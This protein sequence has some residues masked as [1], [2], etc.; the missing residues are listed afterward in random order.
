MPASAAVC[1]FDMKTWDGRVIKGLSQEKDVARETYERAVHAGQFAGL[2][3]Y[4]T[5]DG[6][7]DL[8][9]VL[10]PMTQSYDI[11]SFYYFAWMY[12]RT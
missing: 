10:L 3:D 5:D 11:T 9:F 1:A 8:V 7:Y 12:T 2:V 6:Q 4:V